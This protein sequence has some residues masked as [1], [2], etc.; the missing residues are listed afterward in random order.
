MYDVQRKVNKC[1]R[2]ARKGPKHVRCA[3]KALQIYS[4]RVETLAPPLKSVAP[5]PLKNP[6]YA[7]G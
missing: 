7:P 5:P 4:V 1:I 3:R 2:C 6:S